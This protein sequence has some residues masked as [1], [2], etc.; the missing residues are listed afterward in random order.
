M[1]RRRN[2]PEIPWTKNLQKVFLEFFETISEN[3]L[4][5]LLKYATV[6]LVGFPAPELEIFAAFNYSSGTGIFNQVRPYLPDS[7]EG[8]E[9]NGPQ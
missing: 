6:T 5:K 3:K 9:K 4:E 8:K 7:S 1:P 2:L